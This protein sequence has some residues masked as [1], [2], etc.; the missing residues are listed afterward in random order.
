MV[1]FTRV[2]GGTVA[3]AATSD[4]S[5]EALRVKA[6]AVP[7]KA[8]GQTSKGVATRTIAL[9]KVDGDRF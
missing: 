2:G 8:S 5:P 3:C 1:I 4:N 7:S 6:A 9:R